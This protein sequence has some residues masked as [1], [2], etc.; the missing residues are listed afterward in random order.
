MMYRFNDSNCNNTK[1]INGLINYALFGYNTV[2]KNIPYEFKGP[3]CP[4][5]FFRCWDL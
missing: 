4:Q 1:W 5:D 3:V 2:N